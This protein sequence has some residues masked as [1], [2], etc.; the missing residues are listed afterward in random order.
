MGEALAA[1]RNPQTA[2]S[3]ISRLSGE[4]G[5]AIEAECEVATTIDKLVGHGERGVLVVGVG[6][7]LR[8]DDAAGLILGEQVAQKLGWEYLRSEEVPESYLGEMLASPADTILLVDAVDMQA[9]AGEIRMLSPDDLANNGISTHNCSIALLATVLAGLKD[10]R[11]LVLGIQPENPGWGE[12][13]TSPV[14]AAIERFVAALP[15]G[16]VPPP[17]STG[18]PPG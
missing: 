7:P 8:G 16:S 12:Y 1:Q 10:K 11:T 9:P 2:K 5:E 17:G 15:G 13:L 18:D 14:V 6:N 3:V 4:P